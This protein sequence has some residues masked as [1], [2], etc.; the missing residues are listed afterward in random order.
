MFLGRLSGGRGSASFVFELFC[1]EL[2]IGSSHGRLETLHLSGVALGALGL[3][4]ENLLVVELVVFIIV[5]GIG[6]S[7]T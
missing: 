6:C 1:A 7:G 2:G 4:D 3:K 5:V